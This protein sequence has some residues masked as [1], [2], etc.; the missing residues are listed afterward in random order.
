MT[1][2]L[3]GARVWRH[4]HDVVRLRDDGLDG[5]LRQPQQVVPGL[6]DAARVAL[7][8]L[9]D[10]GLAAADVVATGGE[11]RYLEMKGAG[12]KK[13]HQCHKI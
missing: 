1:T 4:R 8:G 3:T 12:G 13:K 9:D 5:G 7:L 6:V 11:S 2:L 10:H